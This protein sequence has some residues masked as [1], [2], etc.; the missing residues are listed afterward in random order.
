MTPSQA[1]NAKVAAETTKLIIN[2][3][4]DCVLDLNKS[5]WPTMRLL[6][7][8][9]EFE[10]LYMVNGHRLA[11]THVTVGVSCYPVA[12]AYK[13]GQQAAGDLL[14]EVQKQLSRKAA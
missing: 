6:N 9:I 1:N 2:G 4:L 5:Y 13:A 12:F 3:F 8:A 7:N 10:L 14:A 11:G